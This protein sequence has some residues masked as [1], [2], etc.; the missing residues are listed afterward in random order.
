MKDNAMK[1]SRFP[2]CRRRARTQ[3]GWE[4]L[5]FGLFAMFMMPL[6]LFMFINGMNLLRMIQIT[7]ICGDLGNEYIHGVDFST[8]QAQS[9]AQRLAQG[10]GLQV[11]NSFTS[12]GTTCT[13]T[14][15]A[16]NDTNSTSNGYI[17]LSEVLYVGN[18]VCSSLPAGT[19]CTNQNKYVFM[20]QIDFGNKNLQINGTT[21]QPAVGKP[22]ATINSSGW[23]QN[24]IT[25]SG[26]VANNFGNFWQTQFTDGQIA[27]V[28][29][30]FFSS[31]DLSFSSYPGGGIYSRT[32]F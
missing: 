25:D 29:E 28:V 31:P 1:P 13:T 15:C 21:V 24:Y 26:A 16:T 22:T 27:Y 19:P 9:V 30:T 11:G 32:F 5:Q 12:N 14:N 18:G 2:V 8:F 20:Q 4:I 17:V 10:Y 3:G 23:V 7:Q 6:F